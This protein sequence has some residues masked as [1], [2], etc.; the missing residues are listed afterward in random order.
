MSQ[1]THLLLLPA[2]TLGTMTV[3]GCSLLSFAP[4]DQVYEEHI[5]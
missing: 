4:E 2:V 1:H 5:R 3:T